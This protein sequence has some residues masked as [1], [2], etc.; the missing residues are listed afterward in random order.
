MDGCGD[1]GEAGMSP[2][3]WEFWDGWGR[4]GIQLIPAWP[5]G[6]P[7]DP[8]PSWMRLWECRECWECWEA[9]DPDCA[10]FPVLRGCGDEGGIG[11][12]PGIPAPRPAQVSAPGILS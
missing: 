5:G 9:A 7:G 3:I 1:Q 10:V 6:F 11:A 2:W 4:E 12:G 8:N